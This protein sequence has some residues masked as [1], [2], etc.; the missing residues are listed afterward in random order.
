[1]HS[2]KYD[3]LQQVALIDREISQQN[4]YSDEARFYAASIEARESELLDEYTPEFSE[5]LAQ[6]F[7]DIRKN[8]LDGGPSDPHSVIVESM[9][10]KLLDS[11]EIGIYAHKMIRDLTDFPDRE[12]RTAKTYSSAAL[13]LS[14]RETGNRKTRRDIVKTTGSTE[15][16]IR[17]GIDEL[18][19]RMENSEEQSLEEFKQKL[20]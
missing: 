14:A 16:S 6:E 12:K 9:T 4:N 17:K 2:E 8:R 15:T 18:E 19:S 20:K 3:A 10:S 5:E 13:Y 11:A 7:G 1:M